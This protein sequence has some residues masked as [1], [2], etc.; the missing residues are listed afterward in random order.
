MSRERQGALLK[1]I[2]G[3]TGLDW[4]GGLWGVLRETFVKEAASELDVSGK[5]KS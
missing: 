5:Q 2:R 1:F 3:R 4:G